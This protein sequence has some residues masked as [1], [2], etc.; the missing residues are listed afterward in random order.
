MGKHQTHPCWSA[1]KA[2]IHRAHIG[3]GGSEPDTGWI[4]VSVFVINDDSIIGFMAPRFPHP[5]PV[6]GLPVGA[7]PGSIGP[8][9]RLLV[10]YRLARLAYPPRL[11]L[12]PSE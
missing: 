12:G 4:E 1:C 6:A 8:L 10:I 3:F 7:E 2:V 5:Q 11:R 9:G